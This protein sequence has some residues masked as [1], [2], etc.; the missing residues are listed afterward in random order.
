M[1]LWLYTLT[2]NSED[3][4]PYLLQHYSSL[5]EKFIFYDDGSTDRTQEIFLKWGEQ[6]PN[7]CIWR[8]YHQMSGGEFREDV[9]TRLKNECWKEAKGKADWVLIIDPDEFL[10]HQN[11]TEFLTRC[12]GEGASILLPTGY[13]MVADHFPASNIKMTDA[14]K[15]GVRNDLYSKPAI[16]DPNKLEEIF[17]EPGCHSANP[18]G[19]VLYN[20]PVYIYS[21][22]VKPYPALIIQRFI[23]HNTG[24]CPPDRELKLLHYRFLGPERVGRLWTGYKSRMSQVN[25]RHGWDRHCYLPPEEQQRVFNLLKEQ[26]VQVIP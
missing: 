12:G 10:W 13:E 22:P 19:D 23:D 17:F 11:F 1:K 8:T 21:R 20:E 4:L 15:Y 14:V 6:N 26:A 24:I 5:C 2:W 7:E 18:K 3:I 25:I 16:F 9:R